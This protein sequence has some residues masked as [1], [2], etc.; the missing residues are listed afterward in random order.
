MS[1][2]SMGLE[3]IEI[4]LLTAALWTSSLAQAYSF[5]SISMGRLGKAT[6]L[7]IWISSTVTYS[8]RMKTHL[9]V[10]KPTDTFWQLTKH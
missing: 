3:V 7:V 9:F 8:D 5:K 4:A 6:V 1:L 2:S 10:T